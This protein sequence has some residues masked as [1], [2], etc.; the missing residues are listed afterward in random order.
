VCEKVETNT[1]CG[2]LE[3]SG[4][5]MLVIPRSV[6]GMERVKQGREGANI[7]IAKVLA[8]VLCNGSGKLWCVRR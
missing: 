3:K 2:S 8:E 4:K 5:I 6:L 7:F 1:I